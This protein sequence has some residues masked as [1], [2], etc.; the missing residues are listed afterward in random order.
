MKFFKI[1]VVSKKTVVF[2]LMVAFVIGFS[3]CGKKQTSITPINPNSQEQAKVVKI[4]SD[5]QG[6][7]VFIDNGD[8]SYKTPFECS[9]AIGPHTLIVK[10]E[11]Y[12]EVNKGIIVKGDSRD[13]SITLY[14]V[15]KNLSSP[16]PLGQILFDSVPHIACCSAAAT[17]YSNIFYGETHAVSGK[18][19]LESF[20]L[21]LPSK[22]KVH[23]DTE[24]ISGNEGEFYNRKFSKVVTFDEVGIYS[25]LSDGE[26]EYSFSVDYKAKI[27]PPTSE[28]GDLFPNARY[29]DTIA[30]AV[31][32][33]KEVTVKLLIADSKGNPMKNTP[34]GVYNLKTDGSGTVT[35]KVSVKGQSGMCCPEVFVNDKPAD[36]LIYAD[37][38]AWG[39]ESA[40]FSR[41]GHLIES[42]ISS[43]TNDTKVIIDGNDT[44]MPYGSF[45]AP[46]N[47]MYGCSDFPL[48]NGNI[49]VN[50]KKS[51]FIYVDS[52]FSEDSGQTWKYFGTTFDTIATSSKQPNVLYAWSRYFPNTLFKSTD[53]GMH[54]DEFID[55]NIDLATDFV[56]QI[57]PDPKDANTVYLVTWRG[58]FK[59]EDDGKNWNFITTPE[60]TVEAIAIN[61]RDTSII[62]MGG[63]NLYK[64]EDGGK[65]WKETELTNKDIQC[66]AFNQ[67]DP[68]VVYVGVSG[69]LFISNDGGKSFKKTGNFC[70]WG[71]R[72]IATDPKNSNRVFAFSYGDGIY[73]SEDSGNHFT[74]ISPYGFEN[75]S[76]IVVNNNGELL[77][78]NNGIPY[79][80]DDNGNFIP[81]G[82]AFFLKKGPK[83]KI[84]DGKFYIAVNTIKSDFIAVKINDKTIE[85]YKVCD[86]IP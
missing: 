50:P 19:S 73:K 21:V 72:S 51:S 49:L 29:K 26:Q 42:T 45:G 58:L 5:P 79:K 23:F 82:G 59:S 44:Y 86:M 20:E 17:A 14:K 74:K 6:A 7:I 34:L 25:I 46:I 54:F 13:F 8:E 31:P 12:E 66:I 75:S 63:L 71:N 83:W 36:V 24:K 41:E 35:F 57:V 40:T 33:G 61:P 37:I 69:G 70:F 3:G 55:V 15:S 81:L 18:T 4:D 68:E 47:V 78:N 65:S 62:F 60:K 28:L 48:I 77:V 32:L 27:L 85:F 2:L 76:G 52:L 67:G 16:S 39:Y 80:L 10:K 84:I 22:K 9:L 43:I 53:Y 64:S 38:L 30:V 11:G 56:T 1:K